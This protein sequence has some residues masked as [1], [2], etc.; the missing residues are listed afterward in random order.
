MVYLTKNKKSPYYQ[1]I[2]FID[3]KR[4]T[5]STKE[6]KKSGALKFLMQ[7]KSGLM[8]SNKHIKQ[9][10]LNQFYEKYLGYCETSKSKKYIKSIRL[11]FKILFKTIDETILLDNISRKMLDNFITVSSKTAIRGVNV[12][13]RTL[14]AAFTKAVEWQYLDNNPFQNVKLFKLPRN[15]DKIISQSDLERIVSVINNKTVSD[16]VEFAFYTGM[17]LS[18]ILNLKNKS[19]ELEN[20]IIHVQNDGEFN[21]KSRKERIIPMS[22]R[23]IQIISSRGSTDESIGEDYIF[24][25]LPK[26]RFSD[27]WISK[28]FKKAVRK[29]EL[30][31]GIHFHSLRHSFCSQLVRKNVNLRV[32]MEL[33]G[34]Q[35]YS[36]SL[37]YSHLQNDDLVQAIKSFDTMP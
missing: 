10:T 5:I 22:E 2:Y 24:G 1:I 3:G 23:V 33:A 29:C 27:S 17:R 13:I 34:H 36:T 26:V 11:S 18:E 12:Y 8:S 32:V 20:S 19:I 37:R 15:N 16:I 7:F 30:D 35:D 31:E 9:A 21:V 6:K 14:K 25:K 28:S 4:T